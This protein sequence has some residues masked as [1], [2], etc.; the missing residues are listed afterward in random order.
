MIRK[1]LIPVFFSL[2]VLGASAQVTIGSGEGPA[3]AALLEIKNKAADSDN[4]TS[5]GGGF[6]LP[7]VKLEN[8]N[9]LDPFISSTTDAEWGNATKKNELMK[10][11]TGMM[12]YNLS[13]SGGFSQGIY[14]WDGTQWNLASEGSTSSSP[15]QKVF[16]MPSFNLPLSADSDEALACDL[17]DEYE[18]QFVKAGNASFISSNPAMANVPKFDRDKLDYVVTAYDSSVLRD[19]TIDPSGATKGTLRYK[20]DSPVAPAG[21]FIN[22]VFVILD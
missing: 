11:H 6:V 4:V 3:R 9:T 21:S 14:T 22:I 2:V 16:Y 15:A 10:S 8:K 19:V 17:Y 13:T 20:A 5:D 1:S 7:R 18:K 12:V